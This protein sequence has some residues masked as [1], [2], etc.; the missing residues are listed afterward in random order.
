MIRGNQLKAFLRLF[1]GIFGVVAILI[2]IGPMLKGEYSYSNWFGG[3]V[4]APVAIVAGVL[5]ILGAIFN[6]RSI[7]DTP[8]S[9]SKHRRK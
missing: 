5:M 2:G 3:L 6:W 8:D 9:N 7:W 4:F 1:C